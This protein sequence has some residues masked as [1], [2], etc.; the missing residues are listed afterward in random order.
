MK[1]KFFSNLVSFLAWLACDGGRTGGGGA[2]IFRILLA[3]RLSV[4]YVFAL[5]F[6]C[7]DTV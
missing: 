1:A 5:R 7:W 2:F 3:A 6:A 4:V